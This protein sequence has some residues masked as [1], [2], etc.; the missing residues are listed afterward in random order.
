MI[1]HNEHRALAFIF[2]FDKN[3]RVSPTPETRIHTESINFQ[4]HQHRE[5]YK[6]IEHNSHERLECRVVFEHL[7][8]RFEPVIA[9]DIALETEA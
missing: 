1:A 2:I 7:A 3:K 4:S 9:K 8:D 5:R 6:D